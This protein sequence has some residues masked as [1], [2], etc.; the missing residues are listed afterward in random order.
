MEKARAAA[1]ADRPVVA[2]LTV[3]VCLSQASRLGKRRKVHLYLGDR[4][5]PLSPGNV[6]SSAR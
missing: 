6:L 2:L 1:V 4:L 3:S 5:V